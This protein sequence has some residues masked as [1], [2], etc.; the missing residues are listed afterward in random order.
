MDANGG[1]GLVC[2]T[3]QSVHQT[4]QALHC[5]FY[6]SQLWSANKLLTKIKNFTSLS[7]VPL[8]YMA[9]VTPLGFLVN[10]DNLGNHYGQ[11]NAS[12]EIMA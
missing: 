2:S 8:V 5:C 10:T 1:C 3:G 12:G 9:L 4:P 11:Y 6:C 7:G